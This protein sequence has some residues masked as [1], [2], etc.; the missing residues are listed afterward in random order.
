MK[1]ENA[2]H[3]CDKSQYKEASFLER[4]KLTIHLIYCRACRKYSA[5]NNKLSDAIK[6]SE[7]K[8]ISKE[9]KKDLKERLHKE[10][11]N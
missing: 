1:C 3:V 6:I 10:M 11:S 2:N 4:V 9:D 7:L 5:R 8:P